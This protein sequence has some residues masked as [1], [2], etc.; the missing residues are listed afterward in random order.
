MSREAY[1]GD[2]YWYKA[3]KFQSD[4]RLAAA[5]ATK[6]GSR[7][8]VVVDGIEV[9]VECARDLTVASGDVLFIARFGSQ[10]FAIGRGYTNAVGAFDG[11][12]PP[13][14]VPAALR[15]LTVLRPIETRTY[16]SIGGWQTANTQ[17]TQGKMGKI[18]HT[19]VAFYGDKPNTLE[20]VVVTRATMRL[21]RY[22]GG[23]KNT[24]G[25]ATL[26]QVTQ[27]TR[28]SGAPTLGSSTDGPN[29]K[30]NG[31]GTAELPVSWG[32]ALVDGTMGGIAVYQADGTPFIIY[33]GRGDW[34]PAFTIS[35][36][37]S[38]AAGT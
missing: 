10:W 19:G 14:P 3:G 6:T 36:T 4:T 37:W 5:T 27:K 38:R 29:L 28:P 7:V 1:T 31:R 30:W 33:S 11:D 23:G 21:R 25:T 12:P 8:P 20:G 18:N 34:S 15:G 26:H 24:A 17:V 22:R 9:Q 13:P 16:R 32:Q 2:N 35:L